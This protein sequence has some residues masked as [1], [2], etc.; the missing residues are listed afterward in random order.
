[1]S[2][3]DLKRR[4]KILN[5]NLFSII[6]QICLPLFIYNLFDSLYSF[7][8][9]IM[10]S[11]ISMEGVSSVAAISQIRAMFG[12]IGAGLAGGGAILVARSFGAGDF[13]RGNKIIKVLTTLGMIVAGLLC[14]ICIPFAKPILLLCGLDSGLIDISIG[15]FIVQI[16][17]CVIVLF[18]SI[19]IGVQKSKGDTK[20]IFYLNIISMISKLAFTSLFIYGFQVKNTIWVAIATVI[21]QVIL[22][23]ILYV[24]VNKKD[25]VYKVNL[26][27]FSF[28]KKLIKEI[29]LISLPIMFGKFVFAFGKVS[30]N[31]MCK[32]YGPMVVGALAIS[33]NICGLITHPVNSFEEG[34]STVVSQNLGNNNPK[35]AL[36]AFFVTLII[37]SIVAT[38]GYV[39]VRFIFQD[40]LISI[41][42]QTESELV[43]MT[44]SEFMALIESINDYDTL[45]IIALSINSAVLGILY[46]Y[47]KTKLAMVINICRVFVFRVPV[48]WFFQTFYPEMGAECAGISMGISNILIALMSVIVLL[49]FLFTL[50]KKN[51]L[52]NKEEAIS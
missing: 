43:D 26:F 8:D 6:L 15:Y 33:N 25:S 7:V 48:L 19:F 5:G 37:A 47:G 31:A 9:T 10:V 27:Q 51:K 32:T 36:K 21:S 16:L 12:A 4:E 44:S 50:K 1:M 42:S 14:F 18:N 22:F 23:V 13:E 29:L 38:V 2:S 49:I 3:V 28:D 52:L 45:S 17:N 11:N 35:R 34:E 46:G 39:F 40:T 41:F 20:S 24:K 30:V